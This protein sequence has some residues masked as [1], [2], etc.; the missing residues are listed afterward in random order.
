[1]LTMTCIAVERFQGILYPL[2]VCN[3]YFLCHA[4]KMLVAVWLVALAIAAPLWFV[5]KVEVKY[6]FLFDVHYTCCLEVW[7]SQQQRRAYTTCLSV[8]V[9]LVPLATMA[10][11]YWKIMRELWGKHKVH[12]VMFQTLPGSEINKI[13]RR[14]KRAIRMMATVVLLFASC[15]APFHLV[16]LLLD[17]GQLELDLDSEFLL[18]SVVQILGFSNSV[19]NPLV[20]AALN[21]TFKRDLLALLT[22]GWSFGG[23]VCSCSVCSCWSWTSHKRV[24]ISTVES[25]EPRRVLETTSRQREIRS[26]S[27]PAWEAEPERPVSNM[28]PPMNLLSAIRSKKT[29]S[30]MILS[31][32]DPPHTESTSSSDQPLTV[33]LGK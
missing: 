29:S 3:N 16:S 15:W 30:S 32:I 10:I 28:F 22:R 8:L 6:D 12:D 2:H 19:C 21:T 13:S 25:V 23:R 4:F 11:L 7:P 31:V 17:Y 9:F 20:Y 26:W 24:G 18:V 5:Q 33:I 1:M 14:K 27:K